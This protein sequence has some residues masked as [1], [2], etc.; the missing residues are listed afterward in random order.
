MAF[1]PMGIS[2]SSSSS[3]S[4]SASLFADTSKNVPFGNTGSSTAGIIGAVAGV[5]ALALVF[6]VVLRK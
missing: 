6:F 5:A 4:S 3:A 2:P 1:P